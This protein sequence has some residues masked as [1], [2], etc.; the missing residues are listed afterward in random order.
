MKA[1]IKS[2][3]DSKEKIRK[4]D[5]YKSNRDELLDKREKYV[6]K[7]NQ[8]PY[9]EKHSESLRKKKK[10]YY[11]QNKERLAEIRDKKLI[12]STSQKAQDDGEIQDESLHYCKL[13]SRVF[14]SQG[15]LLHHIQE[16]HSNYPE[17]DVT[18]LEKDVVEKRRT[19]FIKRKNK[20]NESYIKNKPHILKKKSLR[21]E[22]N[23]E[24]IPENNR[25]SYHDNKD[26]Y[27]TTRQKYYTTHKYL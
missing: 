13:C 3:S 18:K 2:I 1:Q 5:Y 4:K 19:S 22:Q 7:I 9:D 23:K 25:N 21:Y 26:S 27:V 14:K 6:T 17:D 15:N 12:A 10:E 8:M 24:S 20:E 11:E 16:Q